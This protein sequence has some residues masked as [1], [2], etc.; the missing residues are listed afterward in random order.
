MFDVAVN[1]CLIPDFEKNTFLKVCVG[2]QGNLISYIGKK[3]IDAE[4]VIE[5]EN[6]ILTPGL[7]DGH[8]HVESSMLPPSVFGNLVAQFGTLYVVSDNH[9]IANILGVKG[10]R[11][12]MK[13]AG[14]SLSKI[15]FAIPSSVPATRFVKSGAKI[16]AKS[17]KRLIEER[18]VIS[19]GEMMNVYGVINDDEPYRSIIELAKE[20]K[21]LI[22]G[23]FPFKDREM[24]GRYISKGISD[25]HE[26]ETYD[27][28]KSKIEAG[29]FVFIRE[30]SAET[31][32]DLAYR[33]IS[34][35]PD[36]VGFCTDDKNVFDL[37][38]TG[39]I[40]FNLRKAIK[41]GINPILA[42]RAATYNTLN[43]YGLNK[44]SQIKEGN[45]ANLVL[46]K[47]FKE[48]EISKVIVNG[49]IIERFSK[50]KKRFVKLFFN[51]FK[52]TK[53]DVVIPEIEERLKSFC[54][55]VKDKS[56]ITELFSTEKNEFDLSG[57][58]LKLVVISRYEKNKGAACKIKGFGL[59][60][61]AI[62]TSIS[63]DCHNVICV[64]AD[65]LSIKKAVEKVFELKGGLVYFDGNEF[66]QVGLPLAGI[67]SDLDE[68]SLIDDL[69]RINS[70][71]RKNGSSLSD[72]FGTLSF[73]ALEVIGHV[74]LTVN[75]LFDV[76]RFKFI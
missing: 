49:K 69:T 31:T 39:S 56:L 3:R 62:A 66:T 38:K 4:V 23:H 67:L 11:L 21:I 28:L 8:C 32:Q 29:M 50:E 14:S 12:F 9:E 73:M 27:D 46:F 7:I 65:D 57:D 52:V 76:D 15:F 33:I 68:D 42:L 24:L 34:E 41:L 44:Y 10:I 18:D 71:V 59:K 75:G 54:I 63:H 19:I 53:D 30:G 36:R 17:I 74:K 25:D 40:I 26:S 45:F 60:R 5:A 61:G 16:T 51:T 22:N 2:I 35:Y 6:K 1:N 13:D 70:I 20:K 47:D 72:P 64:G 58:I 55:L 48:F 43:H 37:K